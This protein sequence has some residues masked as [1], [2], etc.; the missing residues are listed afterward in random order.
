[1]VKALC[2]TNLQVSKRCDFAADVS[3]FI[4]RFVVAAGKACNS[5]SCMYPTYSKPARQLKLLIVSF[6]TGL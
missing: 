3:Y 5:L 4:L 1:M 2:R 6:N